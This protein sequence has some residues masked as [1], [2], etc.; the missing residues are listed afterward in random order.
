L[1]LPLKNWVFKKFD[2][3]SCFCWLIECRWDYVELGGKYYPDMDRMAALERGMK[4]WANW[5]DT[6][7]D[8]SR[9]QVLFQAISP[10]HY[11]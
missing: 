6:N 1:D 7:I 2:Y 4:T 11:K 3:L 9:T 5:V 8:R 10:T